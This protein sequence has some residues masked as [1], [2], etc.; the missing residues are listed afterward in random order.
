[1][2]DVVEEYFV[3]LEEKTHNIQ[4]ESY[5][6]KERLISQLLYTVISGFGDELVNFKE[7]NYIF[8]THLYNYINAKFKCVNSSFNLTDCEIISSLHVYRNSLPYP[9]LWS[10]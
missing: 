5:I 9:L 3:H 4:Q 1:M 10:F 2:S 7:L 6:L 8:E